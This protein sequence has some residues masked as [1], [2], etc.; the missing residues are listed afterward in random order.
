MFWR[1]LCLMIPALLVGSAAWGLVRR[2]WYALLPIVAVAIPK[3][4][5]LRL[6]IRLI[7]APDGFSPREDSP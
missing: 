2:K 1:A 7:H 4:P 5:L 3:S 6:L